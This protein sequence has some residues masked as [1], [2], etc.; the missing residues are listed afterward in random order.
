MWVV[1]RLRDRRWLAGLQGCVGGRGV[2][3]GRGN[4]RYV[5]G[6]RRTLCSPDHPIPRLSLI[7]FHFTSDGHQVGWLALSISRSSLLAVVACS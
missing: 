5:S 2:G 3:L 4:T 6:A 1:G 7:T